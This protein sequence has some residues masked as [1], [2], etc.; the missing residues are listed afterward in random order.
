MREKLTHTVIIGIFGALLYVAAASLY[1]ANTGNILLFGYV[2][3]TPRLYEFLGAVRE[4]KAG[5]SREELV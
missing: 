4:R 5:T 3:F 1:T 2:L